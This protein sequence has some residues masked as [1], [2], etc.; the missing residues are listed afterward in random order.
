VALPS[1]VKT[2]S[3]ANVS[4]EKVSLSFGFVEKISSLQAENP[5]DKTNEMRRIKVKDNFPDIEFIKYGI[6]FLAKRE[7]GRIIFL[8]I[9]SKRWLYHNNDLY[10]WV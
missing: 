3:K 6:S 9:Y 4:V 5:I 8:Q 2:V 1:V 7:S 10:L